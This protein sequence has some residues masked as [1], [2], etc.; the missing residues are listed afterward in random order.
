VGSTYTDTYMVISIVTTG[1]PSATASNM[2][3]RA[4][5]SQCC[6]QRGIKPRAGQ[7]VDD[8]PSLTPHLPF[9]LGDQ[10]SLDPD[11]SFHQLLRLVEQPSEFEIVNFRDQPCKIVH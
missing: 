9:R 1:D 11:T 2:P 7:S 4:G 8:A 5:E 10:S 6:L 3:W